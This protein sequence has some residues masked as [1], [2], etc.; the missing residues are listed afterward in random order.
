MGCEFKGTEYKRDKE[1]V[2]H[3]RELCTANGGACMVDDPLG[4]QSCTRRTFLLMH[5]H[6]AGAPT[7]KTTKRRSKDK[8]TSQYALL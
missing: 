2:M 5:N 8:G 7:I 6:N 1:C 3:E 4:F